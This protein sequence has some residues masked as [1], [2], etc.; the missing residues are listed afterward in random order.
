MGRVPG[1]ARRHRRV[2]EH[3]AHRSLRV[4]IDC[5]LIAEVA[6][7]L[8]RFGDRYVRHT[9]TEDEAAYCLAAPGHASAARF[10]ARFAAKEAALKVLDPDRPWADWRAIE[11]RR[12]PSGS[13]AIVLHGAAAAL[14][15]RR[16]ISHLAL[17]MTHDAERAAAVVLASAER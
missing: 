8:A 10:A 3:D 9:F 4:G 12:R 7:S 1:A 14:A 13:C 11:V 16:G 15:R 5:V 6:D 2:A 17:S